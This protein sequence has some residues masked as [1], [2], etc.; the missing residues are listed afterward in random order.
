MRKGDFTTEWLLTLVTI[1]YIAVA[2]NMTDFN[3]SVTGHAVTAGECNYDGICDGNEKFDT[4]VKCYDCLKHQGMNVTTAQYDRFFAL[5]FNSSCEAAIKFEYYEQPNKDT[6]VIY[7][8]QEDGTSL[9]GFSANMLDKTEYGYLIDFSYMLYGE[10]PRQALLRFDNKTEKLYLESTDTPCPVY[11]GDYTCEADETYD[12]CRKDCLYNE[13][14]LIEKSDYFALNHGQPCERIFKFV[15]VTGSLAKFEEVREESNII[16]ETEILSDT[17]QYG[18]RIILNYDDQQYTFRYSNETEKLYLEKTDGTCE[19]DCALGTFK[20]ASDT[21]YVVCSVE[22]GYYV[23]GAPT[24]CPNNKIC[25]NDGECRSNCTAECYTKGATECVDDTTFHI[26]LPGTDTDWCLKWRNESTCD[27]WYSCND[28]EC[29]LNC[30]DECDSSE[31]FSCINNT[32]F[33]E[34]G[35]ADDD[36]CLDYVN[37]VNCNGSAQCYE[38]ACVCT[39]EWNCTEWSNCNDGERTR[40]CTDTNNC[41]IEATRPDETESCQCT[42]D[43]DCGGWSACNE[44]GIQVKM[45]VDKG[46]CDSGTKRQVRTCKTNTTEEGTSAQST[47]ETESTSS[48]PT[49]TPRQSPPRITQ[50]ESDAGFLPVI[51]FFVLLVLLGGFGFAFYE[52]RKSSANLSIEKQSTNLSPESAQNMQNYFHRNISQGFHT[53]HVKQMLVNE[54]WNHRSVNRVAR[55]IPRHHI[56]HALRSYVAQM[57]STGYSDEQIRIGLRSKGWDERNIMEAMR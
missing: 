22:E 19:V 34:C 26:C 23:W 9:G 15:H 5:N 33:A 53:D 28:G 47:S 44:S 54:G 45:C 38:G 16:H 48:T 40:S 36:P 31:D 3:A 20:C 18:K 11:C 30:T 14:T 1:L 8:T 17:N 6:L 52:I 50:V 49:E 29:A 4:D 37:I 21:E 56:N 7:L 10:Y 42:F 25:V 12:T 27:D 46:T 43:W 2:F 35:N 51:I 24:P 32:A 57:R 39:P 41:N 55:T 13:G